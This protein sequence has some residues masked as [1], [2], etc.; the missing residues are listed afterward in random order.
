MCAPGAAISGLAYPSW[1]TPTLDHSAI[2]SSPRSAVPWSSTAPTD[3]ANGSFAGGVGRGV[4]GGAAVAGG[5]DDED[6]VEVGGLDRGVERVGPVGLG[7]RRRQREVDDADVEL[8]LV[9]D[10]ELQ[11]VDRVEDRPA[12][13]VVG[14]LD[15]DQVRARGD[16]DV[17]APGRVAE[18]APG[19]VA[20]DDARDVRAVAVGVRGASSRPG[21]SPP[22][23]RR[24]TPR[25]RRRSPASVAVDPGVDHRDA[26]ALAGRQRPALRSEHRERIRR[27]RYERIEVAG[28]PNA[29]DPRRMCPR[30][31]TD[32]ARSGRRR[33]SSLLRARRQPRG[34]AV[35]D[36]QRAGDLAAGGA[37]DR[38]ALG[39]RNAAAQLDD[40][41][42]AAGR[43]LGRDGERQKGEEQEG[44]AWVIKGW[45]EASA[46]DVLSRRGSVRDPSTGP[47][48]SW[49]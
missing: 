7:D 4:R 24:A 18:V 42:G 17:L 13:L 40:V 5:G 39:R 36:R 49:S 25:P 12:A 27:S 2:A 28:R 26:D 16:A 14:R 35:D 11:A 23:R 48:L 1:V 9:V 21:S 30:V 37:D 15:R 33:A 3:S 19:A 22:R 29:R 41:R 31:D 20:G 8:V 46:R 47:R 45:V 32:R 6:A 44:G 38:S 43:R 10:G 34:D